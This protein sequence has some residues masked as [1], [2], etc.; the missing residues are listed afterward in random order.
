MA[1]PQIRQGSGGTYDAPG[2]Y[3]NIIPP[4]QTAI[5]GVST[6]I[7][8]IVGTASF[9]PVNAPAIFSDGAS[10][11][12]LFGPMMNRTTDLMTQAVCAMKTGANNFRGVRVTDGSD[13]AASLKLM[14]KATP[15][16]AI[17]ATL[18]LV[19][20]GS[21]GNNLTATISAGTRKDT[22]K[23]VITFP[24]YA[25][26]VFDNLAASTGK[27]F[28]ENL[29]DAVNNGQ[30]GVR[31]PSQLVVASVPDNSSAI[32]PK[33]T[34]P[35]TPCPATGGTDGAD[36]DTP[37]KVA[38]LITTM[39]GL[40][41]HTPRTGMYALRNTGA[42]VALLADSDNATWAEQLAFGLSE[43]MLMIGVG[44]NGESV[45][46]AISAKP[47]VD[48]YALKLLLGDY[49]YINDTTNNI[50]RMVSPQGFAAGRLTTLG[51]HESG[52]NKP[53]YGIVATQSSLQQA[54]YSSAELAQL[55]LAGIDVIA[56]PSPGGDYFAMQLGHNACSDSTRWGDNYTRMTNFLAETIAKGIGG[57]I[58]Q[59]QT[60]TERN[61]AK[62]A[63]DN[64]LSNLELKGWIG[65]VNGG[66]AFRVT[67]DAS[68]NPTSQVVQGIQAGRV[69]VVYLSVVEEFVIDLQGGVTV[70]GTIAPTLA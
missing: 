32:A 7:I 13:Q 9:G 67:I 19:Y 47:D 26:E 45:A 54:I 12:R 16:A 6:N 58:G 33:I 59:L 34:I 2:V 42:S 21:Y 53:I 10:A 68:N 37:E 69:Q 51:P 64:F 24:G 62:A 8:G 43:G 63:L 14:D 46:S 18:S 60:V 22:Q 65:D 1:A 15:T 41:D 66:P 31:G 39:V 28:W 4:P 48:G 56:A 35:P 3:V 55:K 50:M 70:A 44:A 30:S 25:P 49:A 23:L 36:V 17:G 20:T 40:D 38:A 61:E 29:R 52:L 27:T 57:F 11:E 5:N